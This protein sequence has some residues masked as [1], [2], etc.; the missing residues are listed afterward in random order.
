MNLTYN[1]D[2]IDKTLEEKVKEK[3]LSFAKEDE[4]TSFLKPFRVDILQK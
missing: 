1:E 2:N 4:S 3:Y